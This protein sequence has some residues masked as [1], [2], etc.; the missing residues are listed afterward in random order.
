[1][2]LVLANS[3][4]GC[5]QEEPQE[6]DEAHPLLFGAAHVLKKVAAAAAGL[7]GW[8]R[9]GASWPACVACRGWTCWCPERWQGAG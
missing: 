2:S 8:A 5:A 4:N 7:A 9:V 3:T 6:I 1:M